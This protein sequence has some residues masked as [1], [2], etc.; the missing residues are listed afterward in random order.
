MSGREF[1]GF[2]MLLWI[3]SFFGVVIAVNILLAVLANESWSGLIVKNGYVASQQYNGVL[4]A[5]RRQEALGWTAALKRD[6][7]RLDLDIRG[8]DGG[9]VQ[10]LAVTAKVTRPTHEHDDADLA[11]EARPDGGYVAM[12]DLA[13][14]QWVLDLTA[15][16]GAGHSFRRIYRLWVDPGKG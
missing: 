16:D 10:G 3:C 2:H 6:R 15:E 12:A 1:T 11:F 5:A 8:P 4:A 9:A 13:P 7:G 14:G